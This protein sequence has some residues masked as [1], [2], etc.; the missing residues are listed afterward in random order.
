MG[1]GSPRQTQYGQDLLLHL[2]LLAATEAAETGVDHG[3][4]LLGP[5]G[6][7][8]QEEQGQE[9]QSPGVKDR[10]MGAGGWSAL[11]LEETVAAAHRPAEARQAVA[12]V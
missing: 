10:P 1:S 4:G 7:R 3:L 12:D 9:E 2:L 8:E 6:E 11:V 5:Q